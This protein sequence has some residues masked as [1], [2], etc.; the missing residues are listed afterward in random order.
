[1][2]KSNKIAAGM[3]TVLTALL[4]CAC[5]NASGDKNATTVTDLHVEKYLSLGD[6]SNLQI[7]VPPVVIDEDYLAYL[8]KTIYSNSGSG[9]EE[10]TW[11]TDRAVEDGDLINLDYSG[12]K[13]DV[14]FDGG[15]AEKQTLWIGSDSFIDGFEDGLIGVRPGETVD[16]NLT[17]PENYGSAELAGAD[18]VFTCTVNGILPEEE[19]YN[20]INT[21]TATDAET[22][23]TD[24]AGLE[25]YCRNYL[26]EMQSGSTDTQSLIIDE[27]EKIIS[28]KKD[29]PE[30][31]VT[32]YQNQYQEMLSYYAQMYGV[33]EETFLSS[34]L[35]MSRTEY[36]EDM[37]ARQLKIDAAC[38]LIA[39]ELGLGLDDAALEQ[40]LSDYAA[41]NGVD[42]DTLLA[43]TTREEARVTFMEQDVIAYLTEHATVSE[44]E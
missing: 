7:S 32:E 44:S 4:F 21:Q 14:V 27:L 30:A 34:Y 3:L 39:N 18:V 26:E 9:V 17:F 28:V 23:I 12:K 41:S 37:S 43:N 1:M 40:R 25:A 13:D 16:L 33:D 11:I 15:T 38:Q 31:I 6:Y 10:S 19:I 20:V 42:V 22:P 5:G 24:M 36:V 35:G 8:V 29:F 2:K